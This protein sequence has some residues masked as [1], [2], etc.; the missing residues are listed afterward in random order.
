MSKKTVL[1]LAALVAVSLP[2]T[3][4]GQVGI[5]ARVGTLGLGGEVSVG[6]GSRLGIRGGLG[7]L[8]GEINQTVDDI[9]YTFDPPSNIWNVGVDFYPTDGGFRISAGVINRKRFEASA[10]QR[11]STEVGGTT[12]N[13]TITLNGTLE[14]ERETAP[15]AAIGFGKT[16]RRGFGLF[17][18][19]G[20]ANMG[21]ANIELT[22]TCQL[23]NGQACPNQAQFQQ[24]LEAEERQ[25]EEDAGGVL[26][27]HPIIQLGFRLGL[28]A[29]R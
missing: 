28:G 27:W 16:F 1:A 18:D 2:G 9:D 23:D 29:A 3:A 11:G 12:Y 17:I 7:V 24:D 6:L 20:A 4:H 26:K 5:G 25:A 15:Y 21:E 22:G 19:L 8:P 13:G 10:V 14:N